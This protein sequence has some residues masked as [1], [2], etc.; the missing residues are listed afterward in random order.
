MSHAHGLGPSET[1]IAY[2]IAHCM[3]AVM[4]FFPRRIAG[5]SQG[6]K[7]LVGGLQGWVDTSYEPV[8]VT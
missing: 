7:D 2:S 6:R 3:L 4:A 8:T 5:C 1:W